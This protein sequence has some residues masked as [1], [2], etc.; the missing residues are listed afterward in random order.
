MRHLHRDRSASQLGQIVYC[1]ISSKEA[2]SKVPN[3]I[4]RNEI[5][6]SIKQLRGQA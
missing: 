2:L 3:C 1:H 4:E 5:H 6:T